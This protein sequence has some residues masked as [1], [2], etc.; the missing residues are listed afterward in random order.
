MRIFK[1]ATPYKTTNG[2][3]RDLL[4]MNE[5]V[6][7]LVKRL[8]KRLREGF[9]HPLADPSMLNAKEQN[10]RTILFTAGLPHN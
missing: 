5:N 10:K 9:Y 6:L 3:L 4:A 1:T 7:F 2:L 8:R